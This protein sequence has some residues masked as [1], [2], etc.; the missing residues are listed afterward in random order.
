MDQLDVLYNKALR[1]LSF[2]PR[3]EK[4]VR[5]N[6]LKSRKSIK[7]VEIDQK[8]IDQVITKLKEQH[9]VNDEEFTKWW[10]EQ[11]TKFRPKGKRLIQIELKQKGIAQET[12]ERIVESS[13]L[14][15]ENELERAKVLVQKKLRKY[16]NL[17]R[18]EQYQK[19][20]AMLG[21]FGFDYDI[22]KQS[23]DEVL[24]GEYNTSKD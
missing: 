4:E 5:D 13:E 22:I 15:V 3:S 2:R 9:F 8:V 18:F 20:G 14:K 23:I 11:R 17:P 12:I 16:K 6:L 10:I 1:F 21:R 24:R 19:L 7:K